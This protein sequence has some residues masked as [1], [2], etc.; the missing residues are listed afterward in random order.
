[1]VNDT[2]V[3]VTGGLAAAKIETD[4]HQ[5]CILNRWPR[6]NKTASATRAWGWTGGAG[7]EYALAGGWSV[8][9]EVLYMAVQ[10]R[11]TDTFRSPSIKC[12]TSASRANNSAWVTRVGM[13]YRWGGDY[14]K[15]P[16]VAKY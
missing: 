11:D 8:N 15:A 9:G 2:L 4:I 12:A 13:N 7:A 1:M 6:W 3:Y 5:Q 10:A 14:G 16:V